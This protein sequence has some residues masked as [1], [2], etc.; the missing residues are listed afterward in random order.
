MQNSFKNINEIVDNLV[1]ICDGNCRLPKIEKDILLDKIRQLYLKALSI[2]EVEIE[3]VRLE[4]YDIHTGIEEDVD[5]FFDT[6]H[7]SYGAPEVAEESQPEPEPVLAPKP[8]PVVVEKPAPEPVLELKMEE[9]PVR[10]PVQEPAP[11]P[12]APVVQP[13]QAA[14]KPEKVIEPEP[15]N[16][17][18]DDLLQFIPQKSAPKPQPTPEPKKPVQPVQPQNK[19]L[20]TNAPRSLNDLFNKQQ[21]DRSLGS[22]FQ[23]AKVG[24]LTKAISINDKFTFIKELFNNRGEEFSAAIQQL[25]QCPNMDAAFDCLEGLKKQYYWDSTSTAY[26]S[27][28]DL[29]RRKYL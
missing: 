4:N 24:D 9:E 1:V 26:L 22:Q 13:S 5:L 14:P 19:P 17:D 18:E 27:L 21:E 25:N 8:E 11:K 29:L 23:H 20:Q 6:D 12:Q 2:E 3:P 16:S 15:L 28:C 10:V 7:E